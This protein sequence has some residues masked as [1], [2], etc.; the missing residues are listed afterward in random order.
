M[1]VDKDRTLPYIK[2]TIY[3]LWA[4]QFQRTGKAVYNTKTVQ[5]TKERESKFTPNSI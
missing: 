5:L 2:A 4:S 1:I 3:I